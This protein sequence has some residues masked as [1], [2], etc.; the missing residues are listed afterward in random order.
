MSFRFKDSFYIVTLNCYN[1]YCQYRVSQHLNLR[2]THNVIV[3]SRCLQKKANVTQHIW[4]KCRIGLRAVH[5]VISFVVTT[6]VLTLN[7]LNMI[8]T[9]P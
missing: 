7:F 5:V 6:R 2:G 1:S 8:S 4:N 3:I 9:S